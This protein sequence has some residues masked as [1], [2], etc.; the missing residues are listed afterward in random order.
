MNKDENISEIAENFMEDYDEEMNDEPNEDEDCFIQDNT[1]AGYDV[2]C[3]GKFIDNFG[4]LEEALEAVIEWQEKNKF[5][6]TIWFVNDHGNM[7]PI[8]R[9]GNEIK[10]S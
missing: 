8:D 9:K 2:S 6:P 10:I 1:R 4:S 5:Y 7:W 3:E